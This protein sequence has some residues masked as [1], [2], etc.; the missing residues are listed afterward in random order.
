MERADLEKLRKNV[1]LQ[2]LRLTFLL[3]KFSK[4]FDEKEKFGN[5]VIEKLAKILKVMFFTDK[6]K[7]DEEKKCKEYYDKIPISK[8]RFLSGK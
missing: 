8:L 7:A 3:K 6:C 5:P 2:K 4:Q 1:L